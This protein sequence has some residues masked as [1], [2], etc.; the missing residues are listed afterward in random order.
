MSTQ[1]Q[2]VRQAI[3][4]LTPK[5]VEIQRHASQPDLQLYADALMRTFPEVVHRCLLSESN[6]HIF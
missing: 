3:S 1:F 2:T 6:R 4:N 5:L